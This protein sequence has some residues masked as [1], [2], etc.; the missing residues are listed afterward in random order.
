MQKQHANTRM[1]ATKAIETMAHDGTGERAIRKDFGLD[2]WKKTEQ[3]LAEKKK[4]RFHWA[5]PTKDL[6]HKVPK[7][8]DYANCQVK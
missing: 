8:S 7:S 2:S 4:T 6:I 1:I 5:G 3:Q